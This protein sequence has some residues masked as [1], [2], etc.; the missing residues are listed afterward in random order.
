MEPVSPLLPKSNQVRLVK[1]PISG[2]MEPV[3]SLSC[4]STCV[5]LVRLPISGGMEPV[6][7]FIIEWRDSKNPTNHIVSNK[8]TFDGILDLVL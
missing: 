8:K 1:F 6:S 4:K 3:S 5:R 7:Y 2:G